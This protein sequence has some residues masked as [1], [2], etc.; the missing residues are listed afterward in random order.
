MRRG[1]GSG[2]TEGVMNGFK[3]HI[4]VCGLLEIGDGAGLEDGVAIPFWLAGAEDDD[5]YGV[6]VDEHLKAL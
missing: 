3:Q 1:V 2:D 4:H 6:R 5:G